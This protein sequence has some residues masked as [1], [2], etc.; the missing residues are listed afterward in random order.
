MR[1]DTCYKCG[2]P[3]MSRFEKTVIREIAGHTFR[4]KVP[5]MRCGNCGEVLY[6]SEDLG[7]YDDAVALALLDARITAS[8]AVRFV[9]KA[10]GMKAEN[11]ADLLGVR[12]ETVSRWE[13]GKRKIDLATLALLRQLLVERRKKERPM[14]ELLKRLQHP[15]HL[16]KTVTLK[17]AS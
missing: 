7:R 16:G 9:R 11:L 2:S 4:A 10:M 8:D 13:N 5:A 14:A 6:T 17:L 15:R 12:A 1:I 3:E